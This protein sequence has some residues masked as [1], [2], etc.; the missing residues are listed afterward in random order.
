MAWTATGCLA[1]QVQLEWEGV[2]VLEFLCFQSRMLE[3]AG[4]T[5]VVV[6]AVIL[7]AAV[8]AQKLTYWLTQWE[9]VAAGAREGVQLKS[10]ARTDGC[11]LCPAL[12]QLGLGVEAA[13]HLHL[14]LS[15]QLDS[16]AL[17]A[18]QRSHCP[19]LSQL[20]ASSPALPRSRPATG[21]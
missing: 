16:I 2:A 17:V 21:M 12:H 7:L 18:R 19:A 11:L 1:L 4:V 6:A 5:M 10:Q 13:E 15:A 9:K 8:E 14:P 3:V 20:L